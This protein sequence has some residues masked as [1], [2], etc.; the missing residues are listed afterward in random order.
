M[1]RGSSLR[2]HALRRSRSSFPLCSFFK[3]KI[4]LVFCS[5]I[6]ED[7]SP[8]RANADESLDRLRQRTKETEQQRRNGRLSSKRRSI[9]ASLASL[10][11]GLRRTDQN[12]IELCRRTSDPS[13]EQHRT[14]LRGCARVTSA[15]LGHASSS[16]ANEQEGA[17]CSL[18]DFLRSERDGGETPSKRHHV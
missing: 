7:E 18:H 10:W 11:T 15:G 17:Y 2:S 16:E 9:A 4:E 1:A 6:Y 8:R 5:A 14:L 12:A 3:A 13:T